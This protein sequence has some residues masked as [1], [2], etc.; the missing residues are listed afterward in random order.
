MDELEAKLLKAFEKTVYA[1]AREETRTIEEINDWGSGFGVTHR[2]NGEVVVGGNRN[3]VDTGELRG[4]LEVNVNGTEAT[5][6]WE[7][8]HA[9]KVFF[10]EHRIP[11]RDWHSITMINVG[12][13]NGIDVMMKRN[14]E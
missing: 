5:I 14:L 2:K 12:Y 6:S 3:I 4:S 8:D 10:G 13:D 7:A 9:A 11:G 1:I